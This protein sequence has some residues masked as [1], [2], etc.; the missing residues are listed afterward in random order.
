MILDTPNLDWLLL[1]K[2]PENI[3]HMIE[4][5]GEWWFQ[6]GSPLT[7]GKKLLRWMKHGI[8]YAPANIWIGT[9]VENQEQADKRIPKLIDVPVQVRFLSMEPLLGNVDFEIPSGICHCG[10]DMNGHGY[11][12]GHSPVEVITNVLPSIHWVIVGGESGSKARPMYPAWARS[13]RDQCQAMGVPFFFKQWGEWIGNYHDL[14]KK[15]Q[16]L[17]NDGDLSQMET[18]DGVSMYKFGKHATGR[19]LDGVE[20]SQFPE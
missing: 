4:Q 6:N 20:W 12:S 5:A 13:I 7:Y 15:L 17:V 9:S 11:Y 2:R 16:Q 10:D 14:P 19:L 8:E 3:N 1:T 18:T